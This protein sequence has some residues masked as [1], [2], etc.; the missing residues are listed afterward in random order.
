[1]SSLGD[2]AATN[3]IPTVDI[4]THTNYIQYHAPTKPIS[5]PH[6]P[7]TP[8]TQLFYC[9][10]AFG[11]RHHPDRQLSSK[12]QNQPSSSS[13]RALPLGP[14]L[15]MGILMPC[16]AKHRLRSVLSMT[17]GNFLALKTWNIWEKQDASTGA[18]PLLSDV[19]SVGEPTLTKF[20]FNLQKLLVANRPWN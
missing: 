11:L 6:I 4:T 9:L 15:R 2:G 8:R 13:S 16:V 19:A 18:D 7:Q 3:R 17:P 12:R 5:D 1:M 20:I 14:S 10:T